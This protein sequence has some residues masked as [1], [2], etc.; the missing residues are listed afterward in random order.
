[1]GNDGNGQLLA[2]MEATWPPARRVHVDGWCLRDGLGGGKR[3]SATTRLD[4]QAQLA[5]ALKAMAGQDQRPLFMLR[6]E[7]ADLDAALDL[8]GYDLVDPVQLYRV[9]AA[10]LADPEP[11]RAVICCDAPLAVMREIWADGGIHAPRLAVMNRVAG[12]RSFLLA[13]SGDR[14]A[15]VAFVAAAGGIAMI[16]AIEVAQACRRLG[17][18]A[19]L[20]RAAAGFALREGC[21]TLALAV[22]QANGPANALYRRMGMEPAGQYHYRQARQERSQA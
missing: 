12:A 16:H 6:P 8:L 11:D 17:L 13:R 22:T 14:P 7:E 21:G 3:V 10:T 19:A 1:M 15:G 20:L 4:P 9:D 5:A 2:A 18:G